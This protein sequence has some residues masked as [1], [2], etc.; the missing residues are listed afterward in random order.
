MD[1][2]IIV[3][4]PN[5]QTDITIGLP[6]YHILH[7]SNSQKIVTRFNI[8]LILFIVNTSS[9]HFLTLP[10]H[11]NSPSLI[12]APFHYK[13]SFTPNPDVMTL[14]ITL[15]IFFVMV[16]HREV[17]RYVTRYSAP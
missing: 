9:H 17:D 15:V 1:I 10:L 4:P 13:I 3:R 12:T 7:S 11:T 14:V 8:I 6:Y 16:F 5:G 2:S